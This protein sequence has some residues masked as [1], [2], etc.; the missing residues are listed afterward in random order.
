MAGLGALWC[1]EMYDPSLK[2]PPGGYWKRQFLDIF[3]PLPPQ[4]DYLA[5]LWSRLEYL[6]CLMVEALVQCHLASLDKVEDERYDW[7]PYDCTWR[8]WSGLVAGRLS[9][10]LSRSRL[11]RLCARH[12]HRFDLFYSLN[13]L[14][15]D[16]ALNILISLLGVSSDPMSWWKVNIMWSAFSIL[17]VLRVWIR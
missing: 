8:R 9:I 4:I 14:Y 1:G 7:E 11:Y 10:Q 15:A 3:F 6:C 2:H 5:R 13:L 12:L 16:L 17:N